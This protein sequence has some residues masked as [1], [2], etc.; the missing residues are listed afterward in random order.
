MRSRNCGPIV[1]CAEWPD[2]HGGHALTALVDASAELQ[3]VAEKSFDVEVTALD[4]VARRVT[5]TTAEAQ[6]TRLIPYHLWANRGAGEMSVWISSREYEIG[7]V[8][9]AGGLIFYINPNYRRDGWRY[10]EAA[11]FDQSQGAKWGCFRRAIPGA[12]GTAIG[13]GLQN[14]KD[15]L[16]ACAEPGS[17][18]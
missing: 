18:A 3:P 6:A 1:Y 14:T 2:V 16:A 11:P 13:T 5:D 12:A 17:A 10:L 7:D 15:M 9:P 8:G 4:T